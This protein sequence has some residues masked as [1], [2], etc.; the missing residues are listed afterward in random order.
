MTDP[1]VDAALF[2]AG[3][4]EYARH[5][6]WADEFLTDVAD[7]ARA[8]RS[9]VNGRAEQK[10][11]GPCGA[12]VTDGTGNLLAVRECDGNVYAYRGAKVGRCR[13][14]GAEVATSE[15]EAWL[16]AEVRAHAFLAGD[17]ADATGISLKTIRSWATD[18]PESRN[19]AGKLVRSASPAKL[20][21]HG[22]DRDSKPLYLLGDV[23]DLAAAA[24]LKRHERHQQH[25]GS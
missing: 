12:D 4:V 14:C 21:A 23:V 10:Y 2:L 3:H 24:A 18:R 22:H 20:R 16:D 19:S 11:L 9:V 6:P 1:I 25:A 13:T 7:C 5:Q 17:I 8:L 15:R